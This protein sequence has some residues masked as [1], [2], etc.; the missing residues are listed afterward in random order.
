VITGLD[1]NPSE[2]QLKSLAAAAASSGAV[3]MFHL[4]GITPEAAT[5]EIASGR[6]SNIRQIDI[7]PEDLS[8][9]RASLTTA[10]GDGVDLVAFGSPHSS[11][12]ECQQLAR[13]MKGQQAKES[14]K[15]FI[16]TSRGVREILA[17]TG[18]LEALERFG[19]TVTADTC[20]VVAPLIPAGAKV[21]MTNSAKYAHYG[22]GILGVD[23][24]FGSTEDCIASAIA[25]RV[26]VDDTDWVNA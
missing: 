23:S 2:D 13:V 4:V 20:I 24:V 19:A 15:V 14:V 9:T 5:L 12:S 11:L 21:L 3:A 7:G 18:D 17:Q 8:K 10:R 6:S 22:P 1:C 25:G 26:I 16:T